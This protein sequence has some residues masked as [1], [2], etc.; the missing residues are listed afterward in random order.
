MSELR[1][2]ND[3]G[4]HV[5]LI[6]ASAEIFTCDCRAAANKICILF[7]EIIFGDSVVSLLGLSAWLVKL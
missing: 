3:R 2:L 6:M 5:T 4:L 7:A 1:W